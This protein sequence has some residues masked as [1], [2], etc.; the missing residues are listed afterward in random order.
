LRKKVK[1]TI[2]PKDKDELYKKMLMERYGVLGTLKL[3]GK[4]AL[5]KE[6]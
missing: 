5:G 2:P 3:M 6:I 4:A 1:E